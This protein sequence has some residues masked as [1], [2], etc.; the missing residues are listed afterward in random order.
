M[1]TLRKNAREEIRVGFEEYHGFQ[2]A[3]V[4]VW[5][6]AKDGT[7]R[8]S[9]KGVNFNIGLLPQLADAL[10]LAVRDA[11]AEGLIGPARSD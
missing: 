10:A 7:T 6:H 8:P 9:S 11:R 3:S 1:K 2:I 4:R 5:Y